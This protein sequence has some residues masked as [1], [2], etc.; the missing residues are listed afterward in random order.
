MCGR[1]KIPI[2]LLLA[3]LACAVAAPVA[4]AAE[5]SQEGGVFLE[6]TPRKDTRVSIE[7]HPHLGVAVVHT[8]M[9]PGGVAALHRSWGKVAYA[10][11]IPQSPIEGRLD[12]QI[13]G[14]LSIEGELTPSGGEKGLEFNGSLRFTG[15]GGYLNFTADHATGSSAS[16][17][18]AECPAGCPNPNPS[19]FDYINVPIEFFGSDMDV[20]YAEETVSGRATRFQASNAEGGGEPTFDAH[21]LEWLR[22]GVAV[23]RMIEVVAAQPSAFAVNSTAERPKFATVRP[24]APFSGSAVYRGAG[25]GSL[26]APSI[27]KLTGPLSVDIF[28]V[29]ARL[30]GPRAK[31]SM[32]NLSPGRRTLRYF[33]LM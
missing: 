9:D 31:A 5:A 24:P 16:G 6:L 22:G 26:R 15:A 21:V 30:A 12:L 2:A 19:L 20:L 11:R 25:A 7:V 33:P 23:V 1:L 3:A 8:E 10:A 32:L 29:K 28:G 4:S 27:G 17:A 18:T 13:P 14:V